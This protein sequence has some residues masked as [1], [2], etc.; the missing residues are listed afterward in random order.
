MRKFESI[1]IKKSYWIFGEGTYNI[2]GDYYSPEGG[3]YLACISVSE[4]EDYARK[5][6]VREVFD[7][8]PDLI[9]AEGL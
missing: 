1:T 2:E 5:G 4:L 6:I 7:E 3:I 9:V 8:D